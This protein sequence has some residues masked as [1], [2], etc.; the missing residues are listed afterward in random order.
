ME[1]T[2]F[3]AWIY[4][5]L[6]P[7]AAA[8]KVAHPEGRSKA[9][10]LKAKAAARGHSH[11]APRYQSPQRDSYTIEPIATRLRTLPSGDWMGPRFAPWPVPGSGTPAVR[12]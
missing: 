6:Q 5:H 4:D 7:H 9:A 12:K 2:V 1:A 8:L 11:N 10:A 3:T